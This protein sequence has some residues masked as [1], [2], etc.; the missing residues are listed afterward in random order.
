ML[1]RIQPR[2]WEK[3]LTGEGEPV[4]LCRGAL[5]ELSALE[6]RVQ[7]RINAYY[8]HVGSRFQHWCERS[9][10][11]S[12]DRRRREARACSRPF[13]PGAPRLEFEDRTEQGGDV[14]TLALLL[15]GEGITGV[16]RV[17]RWSLRDGF[18]ILNEAGALV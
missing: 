15:S 9:L 7:R 12:F 4:L 1:Y 10:F 17:Q 5:P 11:P 16:E 14:L 8:R 2:V 13:E 6:E 3:T 18:P